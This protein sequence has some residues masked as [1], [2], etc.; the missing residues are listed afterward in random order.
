MNGIVLNN[1]GA[2]AGLTVSG[3][4]GSCTSAGTCT[5]GAIQNTTGDGLALTNTRNVSLTRLFVGTAANHGINA[6]T[7]NGLTLASARVQDAG[8]GD[9]EHGLNLVN[10]TG[11]VTIDATTF[12]G[13]SEDLIH[14]E[15]NNTNVTLNVTNSSQFSYPASIGGF[16]NSAILLLPGG[17][18]AVTASIQNATFTNIRGVAAQIGANLLNST[19]TQNFTFSNNTINVT[20]AGRASG[21]V[22]GGQELTTTNI[23][24]AN[25]AFTGAGGNGV[26][27][28]DTNDTSRVQGTVSGNQITNPP[29]IGMFVAVDEAATNDIVFDNNT[30]TNSGGDGIQAVNFGGVGVSTM[31]LAIT[32]NLINGHSAALAQSF[33]GGI[34]FT[35]FEDTSCV[36]L[37]GNNVTGT[38]ASPTQCGGAP[39][40]DHYLE[41]VGGTLTLEEVP[42]TAATTA[43][44]AYVNSIND[45][46]P[47]TI[48]GTI[49]LTNGATCNVALM[50][51]GGERPARRTASTVEQ[52]DLTRLV[53]AAAHRLDGR[54][55]DG[56]DRAGITA[57]TVA[58]L[59]LRLTDLADGQL[60]RVAG[61]H[62]SLDRHAA[63]WGWFIDPTPDQDEEYEPASPETGERRAKAGG[64]ADGKMDLLTALMHEMGH[65]RGEI[66]VDAVSHA[67]ELMAA[68]LKP[69]VRRSPP[70]VQ[71]RRN[72]GGAFPE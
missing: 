60:G 36:V 39:C 44:A 8:N 24:I 50:A 10:V 62:L 13:A 12:S 69:G 11:T 23:T 35:G 64:P 66:D 71:D 56:G 7:V 51:E 61:G 9:N 25:N 19:G 20:I 47:V 48:F 68:K 2:T 16:A 43:S 34:S 49:D 15:N 59:G 45:A 17:T 32:N 72:D 31:Q 70:A 30:I 58:S 21:V 27:S 33:V 40:V 22:V 46:G 42:N 65:A 26:I 37:R 57:D 5:G 3:N 63:G 41:E 14:L 54:T 38:P 28:I 53:R 29:G 4:A 67:G 6:T 1:T 55:A 52:E 18:A